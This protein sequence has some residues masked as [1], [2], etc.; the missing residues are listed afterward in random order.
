MTKA[1]DV[2]RIV[3]GIFTERPYNFSWF[4]ENIAASG[5]PVNREQ[6]EWIVRNGIKVIISLTEE[7][8]PKK[9]LEGLDVEYIHYPL[10]DHEMPSV[11]QLIELA[12]YIDRA[13][14]SS[15]SVLIHCAA[16]LGRTGTILASYLM[17][18]KGYSAINAI[19]EVRKKRPGS[20][21]PNQEYSIIMLEE[22]M[23][24]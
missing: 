12:E 19:E 9:F 18:K 7:G 17:L 14:K 16:G 5:R 23:K 15:K 24:K 13:V 20:I 8:L 21:E 3:R 22:Y 6:V 10:I 2:G 1:G 4:L 11:E